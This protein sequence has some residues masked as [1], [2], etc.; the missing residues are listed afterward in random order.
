[1]SNLRTEALGERSLTKFD[2]AYPELPI[3]SYSS[4]A[5]DIWEETLRGRDIVIIHEWNPPAL[6]QHLL[7]LRD[8]L[9]FR[10]LFHIPGSSS[11]GTDDGRRQAVPSHRRVARSG[12]TCCGSMLRSLLQSHSLKPVQAPRPYAGEMKD[13]AACQDDRRAS[14]AAI[15][16]SFRCGSAR[17]IA[18]TSSS[19]STAPCAVP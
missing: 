3:R 5:R 17:S 7:E 11:P 12:R 2:A 15:V 1:M 6:A 19:P 16:G 9:K 14:P 8:R 13:H 10:L 4:N 18:S